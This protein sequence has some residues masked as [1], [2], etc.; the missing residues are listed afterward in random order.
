VS[1]HDDLMERLR[2]MSRQIDDLKATSDDTVRRAEDTERH[3]REKR[4]DN[5]I[6]DTSEDRG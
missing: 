1:E 6:R 2:R 3:L 5:E 4:A